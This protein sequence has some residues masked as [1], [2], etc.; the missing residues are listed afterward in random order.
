MPSPLILCV[1]DDEKSL[2]LI[3]AILNT[4]GYETC[5]ATSG[6]QALTDLAQLRPAVVLLDIMMPG[7]DG[8]EVCKSIKANPDTEDVPV[9]MI[10]ALS[11]KADRIRSIEAGAEDFISKP[12]DSAE[13]LARVRMLLRVKEL[14]DGLKLAYSY[15]NQLT[16]FGRDLS[17]Y[18][19]VKGFDLLLAIEQAVGHILRSPENPHN[20]VMILAGMNFDRPSWYWYLFERG[21]SGVDRTQMDRHFED[22]LELPPKAGPHVLSY[23]KSDSRPDTM[24]PF[25]EKLRVCG[26]TPTNILTYFSSDICVAAI[27]YGH[28]I[29]K[30]DADVLSAIVTNV[31]VMKA[32]FLHVNDTKHAFDYV[33]H[34]LARAAEAN[35]EDTGNHIQR[36]G[37]LSALL[38]LQMGFSNDFIKTI[39]VQAVTHDVGKVHIPPEILCKP[40]PLS[41]EEFTIMKS[42]SQLGARILGAHPRLALATSIAYSHHERY[43]G[44][45]YPQGLLGEDIPIEGRVVILADQYDALRTQRVYKPAYGHDDT[46]K[47]LTQGDGRTLPGH[48]DPNVLAAFKKVSSRFEETYARLSNPEQR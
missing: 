2:K 48:F 8:Y 27:N 45:G 14:S 47:R 1:D 29:T 20:P 7:M 11:S 35:D 4:H 31:A 34:A 30:Y 17:T 39:R 38:A 40:E 22:V 10:T 18:Y 23:P 33:I 24:A 37:E 21:T 28:E 15:V 12:F 42:H 41:S 25:A 3:Q 13:V 26:I 19:T 36:V 46:V 32:I 44:S 5:G 16:G 43:D 6:K 9:V